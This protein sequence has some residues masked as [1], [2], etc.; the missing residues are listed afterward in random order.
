MNFFYRLPLLTFSHFL[1]ISAQ[2]S[3]DNTCNFR[4]ICQNR[5]LNEFPNF[6][7]D[8]LKKESLPSYS[9][10]IDIFSEKKTLLPNLDYIS[11]LVNECDDHIHV[12]RFLI[13]KN[14]IEKPFLL[15]TYRSQED[16]KYSYPN[17]VVEVLELMNIVMTKKQRERFEISLIKNPRY[18]KANKSVQGKL[19]PYSEILDGWTEQSVTRSLSTFNNQNENLYDLISGILRK[20]I[21]A[22]MDLDSFENEKRRSFI[23]KFQKICP[24]SSIYFA[25]HQSLSRKAR[26]QIPRDSELEDLMEDF[27][28]TYEDCD[29]EAESCTLGNR[30]KVFV[31]KYIIGQSQQINNLF[32]TW[33]CKKND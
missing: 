5:H 33:I 11:C 2:Y 21:G 18:G 14:R 25:A 31:A 32:H 29:N 30:I 23:K 17:L 13:Q 9:V 4:K 16:Y 19:H 22:Y 6:L 20:Q 12:A 1:L 28:V 7:Q 27:N 10:F 24:S 3:G 26:R 15:R 8:A